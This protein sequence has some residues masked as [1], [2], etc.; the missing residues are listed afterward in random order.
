MVAVER[1]D[2]HGLHRLHGLSSALMALITSH[3]I[4]VLK[5]SF[6]AA[7]LLHSSGAR[8]GAQLWPAGMLDELI[9]AT[10]LMAVLRL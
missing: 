6:G 7:A 3:C 2:A 1:E 5:K 8:T 10:S 9:G 4:N